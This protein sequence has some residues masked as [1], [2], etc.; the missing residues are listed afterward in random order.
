MAL[1]ILGIG[2]GVILQGIGQGLRLRGEASEQARL[3]A[4]A[5]QL[6]GEL[7]ER[8]QA[9][10]EPEEGEEGGCRWRL[11]SLGTGELVRRVKSEGAELLEVRITI[12]CGASD[13]ELTTLL[14]RVAAAEP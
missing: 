10:E 14:P 8:T 1:A 5:E 13:W 11:E 2:L 7:V 9:P 12:S 4:T 6:L 3:S